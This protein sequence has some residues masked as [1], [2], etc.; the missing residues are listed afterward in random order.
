MIGEPLELL[1]GPFP[2]GKESTP[3][4]FV[5]I[6]FDLVPFDCCCLSLAERILFFV[7]SVGLG[8]D[9]TRGRRII[10]EPTGLLLAGEVEL[11]V[12]LVD[13][14]IVLAVVVLEDTAVVVVFTGAVLGVGAFRAAATVVVAVAAF[15]EALDVVV[16]VSV[17]R[18]GVVEVIGRVGFGAVVLGDKGVL[19]LDPLA[20]EAVR[21]SVL[22][23][24]TLDVAV[25][26][27]SS[28]FVFVTS[29]LE[30]IGLAVGD[31]GFVPKVL[32]TAPVVFGLAAGALA[33]SGCLVVVVGAV[34]VVV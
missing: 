26:F 21:G 24:A 6:E 14:A 16:D 12:V 23:A 5:F 9:G 29:G 27:V 32:E 34:L 33:V 22:L 31:K 1:S 18:I 17:D 25:F 30:T 15:V 10:S 7:R 2:S 8:P 13:E 11:R 28:T 19:L 3:V 20:G 4:P